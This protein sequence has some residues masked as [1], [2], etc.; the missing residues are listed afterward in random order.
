MSL[1]LYFAASA[2]M[3][4]G[5]GAWLFAASAI[6]EAVAAILFGMGVL[7]SGLAAILDR[8]PRA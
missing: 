6:H 8:L 3:L 4:L 7:A 2:Q 5:L 1:F